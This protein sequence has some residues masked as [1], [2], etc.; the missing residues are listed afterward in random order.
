MQVRFCRDCVNYE[1]RR[2]M[3]GVALCKKKIGPYICCEDFELRNPSAD[4]LYNRFCAECVNFED[5]EG[6]SICGKNHIPSK[7][8]EYFASRLK[9]L[10]LT[11]QNNLVRTALIVNAVKK[12]G[13]PELIPAFLIEV[14]RKIK[15]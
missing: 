1:E 7:A 11:R 6:I 5:V 13:N 10:D 12:K 14:G 8:C 2:D 3:D 4:R 9:K 15:W